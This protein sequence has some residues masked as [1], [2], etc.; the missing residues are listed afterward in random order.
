MRKETVFDLRNIVLIF[1]HFLS[2]SWGMRLF[3]L[4]PSTQ[5]CIFTAPP[6]M[7]LVYHSRIMWRFCHARFT[8]GKPEY[9]FMEETNS[10]WQGLFCFSLSLLDNA[11]WRKRGLEKCRKVNNPGYEAGLEYL[12]MYGKL[13]RHFPLWMN[14]ESGVGIVMSAA[15]LKITNHHICSLND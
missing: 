15:V 11:T 9:L 14:W 10:F 13:H 8:K 7:R 1:F 3:A 12:E 2:K 4:H 6:K 5:N